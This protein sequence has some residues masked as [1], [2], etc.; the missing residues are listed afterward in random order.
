[1]G[2][3]WSVGPGQQA[4]GRVLRPD[5]CQ[6][7][8]VGGAGPDQGRARGARRPAADRPGDARADAVDGQLLRLLVGPGPRF[9]GARGGQEAGG[10]T[11][12]HVPDGPR[13]QERRPDP[14]PRGGHVRGRHV[15]AP[16]GPVGRR[17]GA[18]AQASP[19]TQAPRQARRRRRRPQNPHRRPVG[20]RVAG[21]EGGTPLGEPGAPAPDVPQAPRRAGRPRRGTG[22]GSG[23][24]RPR[25]RTRSTT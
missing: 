20:Y 21:R 10:D 15:G 12:R 22:P 13:G 17:R 25:D 2:P 1:M 23:S 8:G 6:R 5:R 16:V 7:A 9:G 24:P 3:V 4:G 19:G 18:A 14:A 11:H